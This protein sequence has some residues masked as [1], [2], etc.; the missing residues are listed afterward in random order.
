MANLNSESVSVLLG[1][2]TGEFLTI[3]NF[4]SGPAPSWV[5]VGDFNRDGKLDLAVANSVGS[6]SSLS[7]LRGN[8]DG[9][10]QSPLR[11]SAGANPSFLV[12]AD[13]NGDGKLDLAVADTGSNSISILL[14]FGNGYFETPL[15]F[16]VGS[17]PAWIGLTD[18]NRDGKPDLI[19]ANSYSDS[20]S[21]LSNLT[22]I[23]NR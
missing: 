22:P 20:L 18:F 6:G 23:N 2:G 17:G 13:L 11:F 4:A 21:L 7:V 5:A 1:T 10:F 3:R 9:T 8:G 14:G 12:A 16:A 15:S 19:V